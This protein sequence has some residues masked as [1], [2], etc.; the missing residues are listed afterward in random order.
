MQEEELICH[1]GENK[2]EDYFSLN[3]YDD[4][5]SKDRL[6]VVE[7]VFCWFMAIYISFVTLHVGYS[8][9]LQAGK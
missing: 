9:L 3:V 4:I 5:K 1:R 6:K 7:K 8:L 2:K